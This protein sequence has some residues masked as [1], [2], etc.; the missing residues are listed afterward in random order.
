MISFQRSRGIGSENRGFVLDRIE[1]IIDGRVVGFIKVEHIPASKFR[2]FYPTIFN[3]CAQ[4]AGRTG[5]LPLDKRTYHYR[6]LS[7]GE[8]LTM[9]KHR[10]RY[11]VDQADFTHL[12]RPALLSLIKEW[13]KQLLNG[14]DGVAFEN[15]RLYHVDKPFVA[16]IDVDR[17]MRR[18]GIGTAL[19]IEAARWFR[20]RGLCFRS[21]GLQTDAAKSVWTRFTSDGLTRRDRQGRLILYPEGAPQCRAVAA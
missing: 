5:I 4:I 20:E 10:R 2:A 6:N 21:S 19:Y 1:A 16:Y 15:F 7:D 17:D 3:Y 13:E 12:D 11:F 8:L 18:Q 9:L 14:D